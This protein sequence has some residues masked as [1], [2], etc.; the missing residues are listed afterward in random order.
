MNRPLSTGETLFGGDWESL[1]M[2]HLE[3]PAQELQPSIPFQ[4]DLFERTAYVTLVFFTMR[5][6]RVTRGPRILNW[7]LYLFREQRFLNA[8]TYVRHNG[9]RGIHFIREWISDP[10]CVHLGPLLYG[11][12]YRYGKHDFRMGERRFAANV[13]DRVTG[14]SL[15]CEF[16]LSE[17]FHRCEP[18]SRDEFFFER[19]VAFNSHG[20]KARSFR[21]SHEPWEQSSAEATLI[22]DSLLRTHFPWFAKA[23][24]AGANYSP[25]LRDV[26]MSWPIRVPISS[27]HLHPAR[28][29]A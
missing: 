28:L 27:A 9:E 15:Q 29:A 10:F 17:P 3:I 20:R 2:V 5:G 23:S 1:G 26:R 13:S 11:L 24:M 25:G 7:L 16:K 12:P 22:D 19:Y 4:L 8:R 14:T 21:V 6:M 18:G